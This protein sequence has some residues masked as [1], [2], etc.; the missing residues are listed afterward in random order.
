MLEQK[1]DRHLDRPGVNDVVIVEDQDETVRLIGDFIE[2]LETRLSERLSELN[3]EKIQAVQEATAGNSLVPV[4]MAQIRGDFEASG[5]K[6][7]TAYTSWRG[8]SS[9]AAYRSGEAAGDRIPLSRGINSSA[10][11]RTLK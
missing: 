4:K 5:I 1:G 10:R 2:G 7:R 3:G 9:V 6:L 8:I 11:T